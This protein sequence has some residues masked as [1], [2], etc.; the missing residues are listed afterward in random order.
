M[1]ISSITFRTLNGIRR[2]L[3]LWR[4][5][6]SSIRITVRDVY[7]LPIENQNSKSKTTSF[8][9]QSVLQLAYLCQL[10]RDYTHK[11]VTI[12]T[13][14]II[15]TLNSPIALVIVAFIFAG[16]FV[17]NKPTDAAFGSDDGVIATTDAANSMCAR[18]S[19]IWHLKD[20]KVRLCEGTSHNIEKRKPEC[21]PWSN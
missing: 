16:A 7:V 8:N 15:N 2:K 1:S 17:Y 10:V 6:I 5:S 21:S 11:V 19:L 4:A 12:S 14:E 18:G 3:I 20:G 9:P 13:E